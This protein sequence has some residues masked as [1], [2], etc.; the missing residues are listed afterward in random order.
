MSSAEP[1]G[2]ALIESISSLET[3]PAMS[4]ASCAE[5][6]PVN[7]IVDD[8]VRSSTP[9]AGRRTAGSGGCPAVS[10]S[11]SSRSRPAPSNSTMNTS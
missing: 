6:S 5:K 8:W 3:P 9:S 10:S 2:R 1:D 7:D 11:R 4:A